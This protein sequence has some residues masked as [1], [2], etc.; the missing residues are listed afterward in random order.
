MLLNIHHLKTTKILQILMGSKQYIAYKVLYTICFLWEK[1]GIWFQYRV[2]YG[3]IQIPKNVAH[4][5]E[6]KVYTK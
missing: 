3:R 4:T 1:L 2:K 6:T 5:E